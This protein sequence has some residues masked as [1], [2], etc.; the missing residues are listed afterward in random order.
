MNAASSDAMPTLRMSLPASEARTYC[1]RRL[2]RA[3]ASRTAAV[4]STLAKEWRQEACIEDESLAPGSSPAM[5]RP[6]AYRDRLR[7]PLPAHERW[8]ANLSRSSGDE[9]QRTPS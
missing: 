2:C 4:K 5:L 6:I 7:P 3:W 1:A 8:V 9:P